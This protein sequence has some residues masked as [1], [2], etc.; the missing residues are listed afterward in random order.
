MMIGFGKWQASVV[1]PNP[2]TAYIAV[3]DG[4]SAVDIVAEFT[5]MVGLLSWRRWCRAVPERGV[6]PRARPTWA[7]PN[8]RRC[9]SPALCVPGCSRRRRSHAGVTSRG[10]RLATDDEQHGHGSGSRELSRRHVT[11]HVGYE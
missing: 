5:S 4:P 10:D 11:A 8:R 7:M 6:E 9:D 3:L 1:L 2:S